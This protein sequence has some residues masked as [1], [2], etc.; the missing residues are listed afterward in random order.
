MPV[1]ERSELP[2]NIVARNFEWMESAVQGE[3]GEA[4]V[5]CKQK[6][7]RAEQVLGEAADLFHAR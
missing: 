4:R 6:I 7:S 3:V 1:P 2:R 5:G